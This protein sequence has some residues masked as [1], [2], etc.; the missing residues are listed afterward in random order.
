MLSLIHI[1]MCIRDRLCGL[2]LNCLVGQFL[3]LLPWLAERT[4]FLKMQHKMKWQ[5][6]TGHYTIQ[7]GKWLLLKLDSHRNEISEVRKWWRTGITKNI[8]IEVA[9][10]GVET[11]HLPAKTKFKRMFSAWKIVHTMFWDRQGIF[12]WTSCFK[13][14]QSTQMLRNVCF[15][16]NN[17]ACLLRVLCWFMQSPLT[18]FCQNTYLFSHRLL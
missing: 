18:H 17:M 9:L 4:F 15:K 6:S 10:L 1:L 13:A 12:L 8:W 3:R 5:G 2:S 11:L 7:Q 16:I 14:S